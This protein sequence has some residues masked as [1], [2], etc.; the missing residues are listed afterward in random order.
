MT[1]LEDDMKHNRQGDFFKKLKRLSGTSGTPAD[2]ILNEAGQPLKKPEEKLARWKRHF[3]H[4]LNV[5]RPVAVE[6]TELEDN[7]GSNTEGVTRGGVEN[8]VMRLRNGKAAGENRI[9]AELLKSGGSAV[10]DWLTE[11][12]QEIWRTRQVPQEWKDAT[13]VPLH[14]KKNKKICDNYRGVALLNVPSKVLALILL[15]RLQAIIEPQLLEAQCGFRK[16]HG[17]VD[18]IWVAR[19]VVERATEYHTPIC[20]SFVDLS[21][22][23]DSVDWQALIAI[24]KEYGVP[25]LLIDLIQELYSGTWC[26]VRADGSVSPGFEVKS[27]V[28]QGCVLSPLLFNCFI[29]K[30]L[31]EATAMLGG[32]LHIDYTIGGG[33]FLTYRDQTASTTCL[34]DVLYA[35]DLA[36]V[37]ETRKEL[38]HMLEVLD[39]ACTWWGMSIS[40]SKT[41]ILQVRTGEQQPVNDQPIT[42]Q[43]QTLEE[44]Q[45]FPYLG[46]EVD[47]SGK[48]KKEIAVRLEKAGRVYQMWR[49]KVFRSRDIS[50]TTK[51]RAFQ[52]LVM[53]VLLYGAETWPV[54][55]LDIWKLKTFQMRCLRDVLGVTRWNL[56]RNTEILER[57]GELPVEDQLRQRCL[58]WLG[59]IWRM[60]DNRIQKQVLKCRPSGRRRPPGGTALRR[61][62]VVNRDLSGVTDWQEL[63]MDR[64]GWRAAIRQP[65]LPLRQ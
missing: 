30:I 57:T 3:E 7:A 31:R 45:S 1:E 33:L 61:C 26:Q 6:L 28:R 47:Q 24:L 13:L 5:Q 15:E 49:R 44:V 34:Q 51:M 42:L 43:G 32:G 64:S 27:G 59:H 22:A 38:Q 21:K 65:S 16:G 56:L 54:T 39:K 48:V 9:Q 19:Q 63:I 62:D 14:K 37:A 46:S 58:Q 18:Q 17:T 4:T 11:L 35:D 60:P 40:I 36:L 8:A 2:T 50:I 25:Q 20:M 52:T 10:I 12:L 53:S 55:Q 29:D 23:Y 41:K